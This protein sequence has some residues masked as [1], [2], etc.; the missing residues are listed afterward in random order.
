MTDRLMDMASAAVQHVQQ[1]NTA[2]VQADASRQLA[3]A[4]AVSCIHMSSCTGQLAVRVAEAISI[5]QQIQW[6]PFYT[7]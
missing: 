4:Q 5:Q 3:A 1:M 2:A 7:C 6:G